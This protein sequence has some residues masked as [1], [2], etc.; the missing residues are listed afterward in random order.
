MTSWRH[1][2]LERLE[3]LYNFYKNTEILDPC[4]GALRHETLKIV[5]DYHRRFLGLRYLKN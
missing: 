3:R 5:I 1:E 4:T 2:E